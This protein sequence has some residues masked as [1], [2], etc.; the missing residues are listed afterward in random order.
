LFEL[1][2]FAGIAFEDFDAA[3]GAAGVAAAAVK[4]V[5]AGVF[6]S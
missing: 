1:A 4:D 5:D 2:H 6:N 3:G